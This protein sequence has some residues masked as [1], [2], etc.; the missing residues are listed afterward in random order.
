MFMG[1]LAEGYEY[2]LRMIN[3]GWSLVTDSFLADHCGVSLHSGRF[4][5]GLA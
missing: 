3:E 1:K 4:L 2:E 5:E